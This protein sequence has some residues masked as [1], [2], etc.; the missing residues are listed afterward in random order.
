MF[1]RNLTLFRMSPDV[2]ASL[3]RLSDAAAEHR[4][5]HVGPMELGTRGLV[6]RIGHIS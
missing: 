4:L 5:R 2:C 3:A 1:F 6:R